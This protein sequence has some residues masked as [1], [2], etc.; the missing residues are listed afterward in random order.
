MPSSTELVNLALIRVG[1]ERITDLN[2]QNSTE[3]VIANV[4]YNNT[5][6]ALLR[7]HVWR[8]AI[9]KIELAQL[10]DAP[11][12]EFT[13]AYSLPSD[14]IRIRQ[15]YNPNSNWQVIGNQIHTD[16]NELFLEYVADITDVNLFDPLFSELFTLKLAYELA[17][18][19]NADSS[20]KNQLMQEYQIKLKESVAIS[21]KEQSNRIIG[22]GPWNNHR[23]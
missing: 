5:R 20:I 14:F 22:D 12:F 4:I 8:F 18:K 17:Y 15:V 1:G 10:V 19:I 3:A 23:Y 13:Y 21:S 7:S 16:D 9:K 11:E 6:R 2:D